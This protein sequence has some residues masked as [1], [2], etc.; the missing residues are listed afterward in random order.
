[1]RVAENES[2]RNPADIWGAM[3][4][5]LRPAI[6]CKVT[7]ALNPFHSIAGGSLV[8]TRDLRTRQVPSDELNT[9]LWMNDD[10]LADRMWLIGGINSQSDQRYNDV[11]WSNNGVTWTQATAN[12]AFSGRREAINAPTVAH[13][14]NTR[15]LL[16]SSSHADGAFFT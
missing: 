9:S 12:A 8:K 11:W 16:R 4:N 6:S 14:S 1:M 13:A 15:T 3:D 7:I 5:E 10:Y 2:L